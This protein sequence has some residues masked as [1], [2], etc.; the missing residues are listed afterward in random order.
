M[1]ELIINS[2]L[3]DLLQKYTVANTK[4]SSEFKL[5]DPSV[6]AYLHDRPH[7]FVKHCML[8]IHSAKSDYQ[9]GDI[10]QQGPTTFS[11]KSKGAMS[12]ADASKKWWYDVQLGSD[13]VFPNCECVDFQRH[14]LPCKHFFAIFHLIKGYSWESL[15]QYFRENT[16]ITIDNSF[17]SHN[18][19]KRYSGTTLIPDGNDVYTKQP[20]N[21]TNTF[22]EP[23]D[24]ANSDVVDWNDS[25][26]SLDIPQF[27]HK[28]RNSESVKMISEKLRSNLT[29]LVNFS[30]TSKDYNSLR[31]INNEITKVLSNALSTLP[32]EENLH[33]RCSPKKK[34][35]ASTISKKYSHSAVYQ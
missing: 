8:R 33:L 4:F 30:Y 11:V 6:P 1:C 27:P 22:D 17:I 13:S 14:Y 25:E 15:P 3:P 9:S 19:D 24:T 26:A 7:N 34:T 2:F 23:S 32:T 21:A 20:S 5:Y 28:Q 29:L 31:D 16:F 12:T 18:T 35:H 10:V